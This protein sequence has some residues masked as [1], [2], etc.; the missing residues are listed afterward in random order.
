MDSLT[1]YLNRPWKRLVAAA[2]L[3]GAIIFAVS[4]FASSS[5]VQTQK[6]QQ[7]SA[8]GQHC[9][10]WDITT[11]GNETVVHCLRWAED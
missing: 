2:A 10:K 8:R 5:Y 1:N 11:E 9:K 4:T 6:V 7:E 3:S